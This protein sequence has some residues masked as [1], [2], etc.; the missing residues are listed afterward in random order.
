M[1]IYIKEMLGPTRKECF[2]VIN[3]IFWRDIYKEG[4][5]AAREWIPI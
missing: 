5:G 3:V 4:R 2:C 1:H